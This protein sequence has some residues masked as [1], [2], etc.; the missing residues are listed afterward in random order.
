MKHEIVWDLVIIK[1]NMGEEQSWGEERFEFP[2]CINPFRGVAIMILV[3]TARLTS[4]RSD[5]GRVNICLNRN[6]VPKEFSDRRE[7]HLN[8]ASSE[9]KQRVRERR[10]IRLYKRQI[11]RNVNDIIEQP[12]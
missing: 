2:F 8:R 4:I 1:Y 11:R 10:W 3:H 6:K 9:S 12:E 5:S 7:L